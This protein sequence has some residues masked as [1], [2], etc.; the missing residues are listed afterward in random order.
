MRPVRFLT[1]ASEEMVEA[2]VWYEQRASGLGGAFLDQVEAAAAFVEEYPEAAEELE[3]G[4]RRKLLRQFPF[5]LLYTVEPDE[6]VIHA[7]MHL[8][9]RPGY[10]RDRHS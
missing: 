3:D 1:P 5:G 6:I 7:V 9:R 4:F 10:W 8:H 2:A